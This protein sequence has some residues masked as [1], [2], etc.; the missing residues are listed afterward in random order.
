MS[1]AGKYIYW[2]D[3]KAGHYF[4]WRDS[5]TRNVSS[6]IA[7]K[8]YD[9]EFDMPAYPNAYGMAK[10]TANDASVLIYDRF[11]IWHLDPEAKTAP[12]NITAG[13]G[14]KTKTVYRY[15]PT[16][17]D[18]KFLQPAQ[19]LLFNTFN[20]VNKH[21]GLAS[22]KGNS[23]ILQSTVQ[24]GPFYLGNLVKSKKLTFT[25]TL[26]KLLSVRLIYM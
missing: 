12:L 11:D 13:Q 10:W 20:E 7:T 26:R 4:T 2:Y 14:R 17:L 25:L 9:E 5:V 15:L 16:D 21:S 24:A 1:P 23:S 18:E 8:L 6:A 3:E 22:Y 19:N